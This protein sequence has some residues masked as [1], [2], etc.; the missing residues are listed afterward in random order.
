MAVVAQLVRAVDCGSIGRGFKSRRSPS[1]TPN[2]GETLLTT[3]EAMILGIIQGVTEFF[4]IS[5]SGH[6]HLVQYFLGMRNL[7]QLILFDLICHL[8]T[9]CS[10]IVIFFQ[11]IKQLF[12]K[13]RKRL[14]QICLGTLPLFP[15]LPIFK[16]IK[17]L[18][19]DPSHL[20]FFFL[21]TS[22]ILFLG[23]YLGKHVS[24]QIL[25]KHRW[26]DALI[27]GSWQ[28][29]ALLPGVSRSGATISGARL[30]G[31][32]IRDAITFSFLLAI[33]AL[34]GGTILELFKFWMQQEELNVPFQHYL[35]G[36]LFSFL[37]GLAG[38]S[39][40]IRIAKGNKFFYFAWYCLFLGVATTLYFHL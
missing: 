32:E 11:P 23:T 35:V 25:L 34:I 6:L 12:G 38:L 15:L 19:S 26:R 40:L 27:I 30:L 16:P 37:F 36:F 10:I 1:L 22:L 31:W 21:A 20:G 2:A 17:A 9:L 5:S 13:E 18:Y 4:P 29:C 14:W 33:P 24:Q 3:F 28:A 8:G 39:L 7:E